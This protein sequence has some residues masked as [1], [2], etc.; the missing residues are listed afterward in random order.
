MIPKPYTIRDRAYL[1]HVR[2]QPCVSCGSTPSEAH[3]YSP[4]G[5]KAMGK[6]C[7]DLW[8]VPLC[9]QCHMTWH[10]TGTLPGMERAESEALQAH[11]C[12]KLLAD[13]EIMRET[14]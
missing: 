5:T 6:R 2:S 11:A 7:H 4:P 10:G 9:H 14:K 13:R 3:H 12:M 1:D 8:A